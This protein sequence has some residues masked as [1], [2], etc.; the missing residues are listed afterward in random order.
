MPQPELLRRVVE[1]LDRAGIPYAVT[2]SVVSSIQGEPRSS[3][4]IDILVALSPAALPALLAAFPGPDFLL[5]ADAARDAIRTRGMFNLLW[6]P[7]GDKVDFWLVTD[8]PFDRSRFARRR[9]SR[10][11]GMGLQVTSPE[12]TILAKLRWSKLSGGSAKQYGDALRVYEVQ[13]G[14]VDQ[15]YVEAWALQLGVTD[16]WAKLKADAKPVGPPGS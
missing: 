16:E 2:G 4:D 13:F 11:W 7:E 6:I 14:A 5:Q 9:V 3:H 1:V 15:A 10:V 8:D 12:D